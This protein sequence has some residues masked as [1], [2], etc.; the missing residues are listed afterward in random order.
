M[1]SLVGFVGRSTQLERLDSFRFRK[2]Q[3]AIEDPSCNLVQNHSKD[4]GTV[5]FLTDEGQSQIANPTCGLSIVELRLLALVNSHN[6]LTD[7]AAKV[8]FDDLVPA[9][10]RLLE[11]VFIKDLRKA[12]PMES[13]TIAGFSATRLGQAPRP[14]SSPESFYVVRQVTSVALREQ[15]MAAKNALCHKIESC[16]C[17]EDLRKMLRSLDN[18]EAQNQHADTLRTLAR[19]FGGLLL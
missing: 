2:I 3:G 13:P 10:D 4:H 7:L 12:T 14:A 11:L 8:R 15:F 9:V 17:P 18:V 5:F 16:T 1:I 19:H 6:T